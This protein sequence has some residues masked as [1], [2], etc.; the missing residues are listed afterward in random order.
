MQLYVQVAAA[1]AAVQQSVCQ[2]AEYLA[3]DSTGLRVFVVGPYAWGTAL[4]GANP[5]FGVEGLLER[6]PK[7]E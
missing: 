6:I 4:R 1:Q 3:I 2:L 7:K 5:R